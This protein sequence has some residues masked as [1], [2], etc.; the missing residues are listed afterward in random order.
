MVGTCII[1]LWIYIYSRRKTY[2]LKLSFS[3]Y[4][5]NSKMGLKCVVYAHVDKMGLYLI[6]QLVLILCINLKVAFI[7]LL[8]RISCAKVLR[9]SS[10]IQIFYIS[11][12]F[13]RWIVASLT[14]SQKM[15]FVKVFSDC[16]SPC[17]SR[18][19]QDA[20]FQLLTACSI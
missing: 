7:L 10:K 14:S 15:S 11:N 18:D 3:M 17:S 2:F 1:N 19:F 6:Q 8:L 13:C 20:R 12:N 16:F 5:I 9:K 4:L